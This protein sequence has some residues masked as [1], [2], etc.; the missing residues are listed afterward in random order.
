MSRNFRSSSLSR[1]VIHIQP[2]AAPKPPMGAPCNGCGLCCLVEPC[3]VGVVLSRSSSGPCK[4]LRWD[5]DG[6]LYRCGALGSGLQARVLGRWIA[7]GSGCDCNLEPV[8]SVTIDDSKP[9]DL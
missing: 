2:Q 9:A 7:A 3:P 8:P 4:A 1:Q 5:E 6:K